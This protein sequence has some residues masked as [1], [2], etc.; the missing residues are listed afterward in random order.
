MYENYSTTAVKPAHM[1]F[2]GVYILHVMART[3]FKVK[4]SFQNDLRVSHEYMTSI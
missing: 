4:G 2:Y 3:V 1:L